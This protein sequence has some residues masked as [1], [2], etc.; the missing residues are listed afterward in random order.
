MKETQRI[1]QL[2]EKGFNGI[3]WID[4]NLVDVL[5]N[6][7]PEQAIRKLYPNANSIWEITNH[8]ISWRENVLQRVQGIEIKTPVHNYFMPL[9]KGAITWKETLKKL[10][11][12]QKEWIKFLNDFKEQDFEVVYKPNGMNYY[13]HIHGILQHDV[14]HLGQ[15]VMLTRFIEMDNNGE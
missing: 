15:I 12:S 13:E 6:I 1:I 10:G 8:I 9:Q 4:V 3:P 14:Y 2:F 7:T 11:T 5:E